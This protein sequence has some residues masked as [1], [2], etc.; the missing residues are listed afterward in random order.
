AKWKI[1]I[2]KNIPDI[3]KL[4]HGPILKIEEFKLLFNDNSINLSDEHYLLDKHSE[5]IMLNRIYH[6]KRAEITYQAG[7][8]EIP[9]SIKQGI[10]E[11]IAKL[12]D[13]R[14][15]NQSLPAS[16]KSLYQPFK[17]VRL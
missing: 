10:I 2:F 17:R 6:A 14:G 4:K 5:T 16:V 3:I 11:H 12:Y 8:E 7:Y 1:S 15:E 9:A 13:L